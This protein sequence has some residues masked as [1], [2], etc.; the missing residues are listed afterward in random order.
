MIILDTDHISILQRPSQ[1]C[2]RLVAK[3]DTSNTLLTTSVVTLEEQSRSWIAEIG[4]RREVADQ[5]I[6]Y[7]RL[8]NMFA[9]FEEWEIVPFSI[10]AAGIF[11]TMREN[12]VR[13]AAT[14]LKI[15]S[16]ALVNDATLLTTNTRDFERVPGLRFDNWIA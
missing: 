13:I 3:L 5:V 7:D 1:A 11:K 15:A 4:R 8:L 6:P 9:F 2:D 12:R 14:D 10:E 16:I